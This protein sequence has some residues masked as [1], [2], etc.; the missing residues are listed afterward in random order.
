MEQG[1]L[2]CLNLLALQ[3]DNILLVL[4]FLMERF[5]MEQG[6]LVAHMEGCE[7]VVDASLTQAFQRNR[8]EFRNLLFFHQN[9]LI[10]SNTV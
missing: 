4:L 2:N 6:L 1:M 9:S 7:S 5:F 3:T 10:V 8:I